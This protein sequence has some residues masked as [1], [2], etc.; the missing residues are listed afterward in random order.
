MTA[1]F[2]HDDAVE[3]TKREIDVVY[4]RDVGHVT[5]D[6]VAIYTRVGEQKQ[7]ARAAIDRLTGAPYAIKLPNRFGGLGETGINA[8]RNN[9]R[10]EGWRA[11]RLANH[12]LWL[13]G[14]SVFKPQR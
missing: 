5:L 7:L 2:H 13:D 4:H 11:G 12:S 1:A 6:E 8:N 9:A 14:V 3:L 10:D